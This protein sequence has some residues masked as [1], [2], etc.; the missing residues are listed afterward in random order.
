MKTNKTQFK[1]L[2]YGNYGKPV[3]WA[4][5]DCLDNEP[6]KIGYNYQT[7]QALLADLHRFATERGFETN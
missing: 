6:A 2:E 3:I 7:K 4:F 5:F 1:G